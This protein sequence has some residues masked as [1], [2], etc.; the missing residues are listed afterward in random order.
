[1]NAQKAT[2]KPNTPEGAQDHGK[3][4]EKPW[5][6]STGHLEENLR[7][8]AEENE[9]TGG[10]YLLSRGISLDVQKRFKVGLCHRW[11]DPRAKAE[12]EAKGE[13]VFYDERVIF[14]TSR[15]TYQ[16]R[17]TDPKAPA[18]LKARKFGNSIPFNLK[19]LEE[20][21]KDGKPVFILEGEIDAL[22]LEEVNAHGLGLGGVGN[23]SFLLREIGRT[24]K[25]PF[26]SVI[27]ALDFDFAGRKASRALVEG[28]KGL[29]VLAIEAP[30]FPQNFGALKAFEATLQEHER[31]PRP[32]DYLEEEKSAKAFKAFLQEQ[33]AKGEPPTFFKD[34]NELLQADPEGLTAWATLCEEETTFKREAERE[35]YSREF[36]QAFHDFASN[37][38]KNI[39]E[40]PISTGFQGL[41]RLLN[42]G[43]ENRL[44]ILGAVPSLGKSTFILQMASRIAESGKD[45]LFFALEMASSELISKGLSCL[46]CRGAIEK[47]IS[48]GNSRTAFEISRR[49]K[50]EEFPKLSKELLSQSLSFYGEKIAPRL[51][52]FEGLGEVGLPEIRGAIERHKRATGR[53]PVVFID[54][55][56]I[57]RIDESARGLSDKQVIDKNVLALKKISKEEGLPV[58][59]VSSFGR[60]NYAEEA[61]QNSFKESGAIEYGAD[62]LLALQLQVI[63]SEDFT[64][65]G[66]TEGEKRRLIKEALKAKNESGVNRREIMLQVLK[67]R[68]GELGEIPF[69]F[70]PAY[71]YFLEPVRVEDTGTAP[72]PTTGPEDEEEE[73]PF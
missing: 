16:A 34:P 20:A 70:Y 59:C 39:N 71:N 12:R 13:R 55:L 66:T 17:A 9:R 49:E 32:L 11:T 45:V 24:M 33:E 7:A 8:W 53:A 57:M 51:F 62:V 35:N 3:A 23:A 69:R 63:S 41:D 28:L 56:Q 1:M 61:G 38:D 54:Y 30:L 43:L 65:K 64:K 29:G 47:K 68:G 67:N 50:W 27:V 2:F 46:T 15:G 6:P 72:T 60:S 26:P 58:V 52:I 42:G 48:I 5:E 14:W 44:Y 37:K 22:S 36:L 18:G 31:R 21:S 40:K 25:A 19:A 4:L 73:I 10:K